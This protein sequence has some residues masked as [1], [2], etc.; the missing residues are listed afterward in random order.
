MDIVIV[1]LVASGT[2][3]SLLSAI[4]VFRMP[5]LY[6]RMQATTKCSTLGVSSLVLA[7]ALASGSTGTTVRALLIIAFLFLTA[8]V[9]AHMI[10]R[11][12]YAAGVPLWEHSV[13]DEL[14]QESESRETRRDM[15]M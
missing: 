8:P 4:G 3:F 11:A 10:G 7:A 5:D 12:A 14:R 6:T 9:A 15:P 2:A 1:L 13:I